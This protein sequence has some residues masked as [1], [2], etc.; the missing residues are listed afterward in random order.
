MCLHVSGGGHFS[1]TVQE[2]EIQPDLVSPVR[3][4]PCYPRGV[5]LVDKLRTNLFFK[6]EI[7][8]QGNRVEI[9]IEVLNLVLN[10]LKLVNRS[11]SDS[12]VFDLQW[13]VSDTE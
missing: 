9:L 12:D 6:N 5:L 2:E 11:L 1:E 10:I 8:E 4:G 3:S 13:S 7:G